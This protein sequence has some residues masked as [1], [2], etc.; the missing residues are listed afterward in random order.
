MS[1]KNFSFYPDITNN[2]FYK[3]ITHKKEFYSHRYGK[4]YAKKKAEDLCNPLDKSLLPQQ[5]FLKNFMS[6]ETPYNS[7]LVFHGTGSGKTC[8]AV[9]IAESYKKQIENRGKKILV[10]LKDNL[11]SNFKNTIYNLDLADLKEDEEMRVQCTGD[12]YELDNETNRYLSREQKKKKIDK[13]IKEYYQ[14]MGYRKFAN[15]IM[16]R[17][18]WDGIKSHLDKHKIN[19]IRREFSNRVIIID[20]IHNIKKD[21]SLIDMKK[22]GPIIET[23]IKLGLNNKLVIMSATP[24]YDQPDEI[25]FLLNL[26]RYNDKRKPISK[27]DVFDK[28]NNLKPNGVALIKDACRGYISYFRGQDPIRFPIKIY[29]PQSKIINYKTNFNGEK[30]PVNEYIK[31]TKL[32]PCKMS[33][34]Q[35]NAYNLISDKEKEKDI[36]LIMCSNFAMVNKQNK[37]I[38]A[39]H[40]YTEIDN[41]NAMFVRKYKT[42]GDKTRMQYSYQEHILKN[43]N[44]PNE[45]AP[46]SL[47]NIG[48]Y[49][50]KIKNIIEMCIKSRGPIFI[51]SRFI[52]SGGILLALAL[53]QNGFQRYR[54]ENSYDLLDY[55]INKSGGGGKC[56]PID[57]ENGVSIKNFKST[58]R[59]FIPAK[60]LF[61][62]RTGPGSIDPARAAEIISRETNSNGEEVKVIIGTKTLSEGID[63]KG[64]RQINVMEPWYNLSSLD[65]I[66]GRAIR[67]CSHIRLPENERNVEVCLYASIPPKQTDNE[68]IDIKSYRIA[69]TKDRKIKQIER[70]LKENAVDCALNYPFNVFPSSKSIKMKIASGSTITIKLGDQDYSRECD[71]QKCGFKC[72][73]NLTDNIPDKNIN[74][75]TY[76][77]RY[78]EQELNIVEKIIRKIFRQIYVITLPDLNKIIKNLYPNLN[79]KYISKMINTIVEN[80]TILRDKYNRKG[81][82][83]HK[84]KYFI[85]QPLDLSW[86]KIPL[87]YRKTPLTYKPK[88]VSIKEYSDKLEK[89]Y[90]QMNKSITIKDIEQRAID[91]YNN[92]TTKIS[93]KS[94]IDKILPEKYRIPILMLYLIDRLSAYQ[95]IT[96]IVEAIKNKTKF[97]LNNYKKYFYIENNSI[98]GILLN[99]KWY[100][101]DNNWNICET[102]DIIKFSK[103]FKLPTCNINTKIY[104]I[105]STEKDK[106][107]F[108]IID[109]TKKTGAKSIVGT[110]SKRSEIKG[111]VCSTLTLNNLERIIKELD[112]YI[113]VKNKDIICFQIEIQFRYWDLINYKNHKWIVF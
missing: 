63:F 17:I 51:Y 102:P 12:T 78:I 73:Y 26:M 75:N 79:D 25:I 3:K 21:D 110:N 10:L 67:N 11:I 77:L 107:T 83:I 47:T 28:N 1:G 106:T 99:G 112:L 93:N 85:Y 52:E 16:R 89:Y 35:Y 19:L 90:N 13:K 23:I 4:H 56:P 60:Y 36:D 68:T 2:D 104:G 72:N 64:L 30:I 86:E 57:Y 39:K 53:E 33:T 27:K 45:S 59:N 97:I 108:K 54:T 61:V 55:P 48:I 84:G 18:G 98:M 66:I 94:F 20:E 22:T 103:N 101:K 44:K 43:R 31:Y 109:K 32:I 76:S 65:Q 40:L 46:L 80:K 37:P 9:Q 24:M 42:Y 95:K 111:Q 38:Y 29:S 92:K 7:I 6:I 91:L 34:E 82:I 71:Y 69:E 5:M 49:S 96:I 41:G 100:C 87:M 70:I 105:I 58:T 113:T 8:A 88:M 81:Y 74:E 62:S 14:F 50:D 15:Y